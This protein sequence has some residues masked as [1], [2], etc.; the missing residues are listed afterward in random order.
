[1]IFYLFL[2]NLNREDFEHMKVNNKKYNILVLNS[3]KPKIPSSPNAK[4][5]IS[6]SKTPISPALT[7]PYSAKKPTFFCR[8]L[9]LPLFVSAR[10]SLGFFSI[11]LSFL[12]MGVGW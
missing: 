4:A 7:N 5:A 2:F 11:R 3:G 6:N 9:L 1:M 10:P 12:R 8:D